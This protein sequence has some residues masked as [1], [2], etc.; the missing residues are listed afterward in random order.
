MFTKLL[1]I[2][3]L[4]ASC[5]FLASCGENDEPDTPDP[6]PGPVQT[7]DRTVLVY[8]VADNNL[9]DNRF[10]DNDLNEMKKGAAA[11]GLNGGRLLVYHNRPGTFY[12]KSPLL[13]EITDQGIDTLK[14]YPDDPSVYSVEISRMREVL[15]DVKEAAPAL[16]YG[17]V[18]WGH[19]TSWM[20]HEEMDMTRS[21][22]SDRDRWMS[23]TSLGKALDGEQF[24]FIYFDCCLMGTVEIAYEFRNLTPYIV[25][26]PTELEG[27]GMPYHLNLP[28]FFAKGSPDVIAM[29]TNTFEYY[30][31]ISGSRCQ[32]VVIDTSALGDLA[33]ATRDIYATQTGFPDALSEVQPLSQTHRKYVTT[34]SSRCNDCRPVYDMDHYME[35]MTA[36]RPEL[37]TAWRGVLDH[38][39]AYK[40]TTVYEFTGIK[41]ARYCGLGSYVVRFLNHGNYHGY[42][43]TQW[44]ED[45]VSTAPV[46]N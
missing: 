10:N 15:A 45:V 8:M 34:S 33:S 44:W 18:F 16:D 35:V 17:L 23:L 37:L 30:Q 29:A 13:L 22:G 41:V 9:G 2:L 36:D 43:N 21:I 24:S 7:V 5:T 14:T 28:A 19:A 32:M 46:F 3:L 31:L 20:S 39:V 40:A 38:T 25:A 6:K 4:L 12:G 27:E 26:S 42:T 1:N 11:G